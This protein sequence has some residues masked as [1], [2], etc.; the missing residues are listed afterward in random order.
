MESVSSDDEYGQQCET[1]ASDE[2]SL[3]G[4]LTPEE[5]HQAILEAELSNKSP[6]LQFDPWDRKFL[7]RAQLSD[8]DIS[9]I[10]ELVL[11]AA[12]ME[13]DADKIVGR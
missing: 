11:D 12:V 6:V 10:Y 4:S 2:Q 3:L 8:P 13:Q 7:Q 1:A 5:R 9:F